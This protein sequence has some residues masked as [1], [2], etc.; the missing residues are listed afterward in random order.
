[1]VMYY[2]FFNISDRLIL[3]DLLIVQINS[4]G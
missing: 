3:N 1:M 2:S 4:T